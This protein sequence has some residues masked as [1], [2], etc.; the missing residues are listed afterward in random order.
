MALDEYSRGTRIFEHLLTK[1]VHER[2]SNKILIYR[3][4]GAY[5]PAFKFLLPSLHTHVGMI[6]FGLYVCMTLL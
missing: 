5:Y 6:P 1:F 3:M 4:K 2:N